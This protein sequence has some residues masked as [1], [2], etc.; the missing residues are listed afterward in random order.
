MHI[1][2]KNDTFLAIFKSFSLLSYLCNVDR[3]LWASTLYLSSPKSPSVRAI[4]G[5]G[6]PFS[7]DLSSSLGGSGLSIYNKLEFF[8]HTCNCTLYYLSILN[9]CQ[10]WTPI[11]VTSHLCFAIWGFWRMSSEP[12]GGYFIAFIQSFMT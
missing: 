8:R 10:M 4:E 3:L 6:L 11:M 1:L 2:R 12:F 5:T 7:S 9:Q